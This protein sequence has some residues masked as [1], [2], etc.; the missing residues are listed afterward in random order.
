M[1]KPLVLR[2]LL[3]SW[4]ETSC[5]I[6]KYVTSSKIDTTSKRPI[7]G[8][9]CSLIKNDFGFWTSF[10]FFYAKT[11][12]GLWLSFNFEDCLKEMQKT[13]L[14]MTICFGAI[15]F[16]LNTWEI[17]PP[18]LLLL[19]FWRKQ[20]WSQFYQHFISNFVT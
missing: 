9:V 20:F 15:F 11:E 16:S 12:E 6:C 18:P 1:R 3:N 10:L 2:S 4:I 8:T 17:S 7:F 5:F 13:K 14:D 19:H